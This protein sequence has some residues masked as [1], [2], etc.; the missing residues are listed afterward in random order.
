VTGFCKVSF[1]PT[2]GT[3]TLWTRF[4]IGPS[5]VPGWESINLPAICRVA[6]AV[7]D[8]AME[9]AKPAKTLNLIVEPICSGLPFM[10]IYDTRGKPVVTSSRQP[11]GGN[12]GYPAKPAE[13]DW[14]IEM[15]KMSAPSISDE[16]LKT[17]HAWLTSRGHN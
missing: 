11:M 8:I 2:T 9:Q 5:P 3:F 7:A 12:I 4:Q 14:F 16:E 17:V 10:V 6:G 1:A 13:I 15:L